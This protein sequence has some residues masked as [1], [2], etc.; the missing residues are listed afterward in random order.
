MPTFTDLNPDEFGGTDYPAESYDTG[1]STAMSSTQ[2]QALYGAVE[3]H[4]QEAE[5]TRQTMSDVE[6]RL[7]EANC[8]KVLLNN[9]LFEERSER[10]SSKGRKER[11]GL[12]SRRTEI[13]TR[14][15][16]T[17]TSCGA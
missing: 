14:I 5:E 16:N 10:N 11:K 9:S 4:L 17:R 15:G 2:A 8:Y 13:S 7:E 6:L 12:Y 1:Y 3:E